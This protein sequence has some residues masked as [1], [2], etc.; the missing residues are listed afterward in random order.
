M[1]EGCEQSAGLVGNAS[2]R[3]QRQKKKKKQRRE[4]S[5]S[6][7]QSKVNTLPQTHDCVDALLALWTSALWRATLVALAMTRMPG[8]CSWFALLCTADSAG[9]AGRHAARFA[10]RARPLR[11]LLCGASGARAARVCGAGSG[12][13]S[14][15]AVAT[16]LL[17]AAEAVNSPDSRA[18]QERYEKR[19]RMRRKVDVGCR[20]IEH[21]VLCDC[22]CVCL[23]VCTG[24]YLAAFGL[25]RVPAQATK[26]GQC[27]TRRAMHLRGKKK[28]S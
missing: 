22:P 3:R 14:S 11:A 7:A 10:P 27:S 17:V 13:G 2:C 26:G 18:K 6:T 12:S 9:F 1:S 21:S 8:A 5:R 28:R 20:S 24:K 25:L 19:K 15:S 23:P 4:P 16:W